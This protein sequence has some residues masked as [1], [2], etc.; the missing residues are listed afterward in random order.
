MNEASIMGQESV[1]H[2]DCAQAQLKVYDGGRVDDVCQGCRRT[3]S[4]LLREK[5]R[6]GTL[7]LQPLPNRRARRAEA[8]SKR[9]QK[10]LRGRR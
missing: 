9:Q 2:C 1:K 7:R 4:P 10:S 8:A 6:T 3:L 5:L